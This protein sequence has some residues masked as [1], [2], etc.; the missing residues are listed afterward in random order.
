MW[1]LLLVPVVC[2]ALA[3]LL[4]DPVIVEGDSGLPTL[5][6]GD[7]LLAIRSS[8][9][10]KPT[11]G[12]LVVIRGPFGRYMVKRVVGLPGERV[13]I[14]A[15]GLSIDGRMMDEPYVIW[16]SDQ[17]LPTGDWVLLDGADGRYFLLGDNRG[18]STDSRHF[19]GVPRSRVRSRAVFRVWPVSRFGPL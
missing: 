12:E 13:T 18:M 4:L 10:K 6:P 1:W 8:V 9:F 14:N 11:R 19:G 3:R 7:L 15:D 16:M 5:L 17:H 2:I